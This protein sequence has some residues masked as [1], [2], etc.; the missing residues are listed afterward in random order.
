MSVLLTIDEVNALPSSPSEVTAFYKLDDLRA[1][2]ATPTDFWLILSKGAGTILHTYYWQFSQRYP[3]APAGSGSY[4]NVDLNELR[5]L[6]DSG[7][8]VRDTTFESAPMSSIL[9]FGGTPMFIRGE[10]GGMTDATD[11][12]MSDSVDFNQSDSVH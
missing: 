7:Q 8:V 2:P 3:S 5:M 4:I 10:P 12:N 1:L 11:F 9:Q 6:S